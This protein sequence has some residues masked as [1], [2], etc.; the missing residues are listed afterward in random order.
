MTFAVE[1]LTFNNYY[2][3]GGMIYTES[4]VF[5]VNAFM[6]PLIWACDPWAILKNRKRKQELS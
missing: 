5:I 1:L 2:G 6:P 3:M 4:I